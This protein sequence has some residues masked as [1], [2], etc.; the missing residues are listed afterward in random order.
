M[1]D[2]KPTEEQIKEFWEGCGFMW[3]KRGKYE[4]DGYIMFAP[5]KFQTYQTHIWLPL[6]DLNNLFKYAVPKTY[7]PCQIEL[8]KD[9]DT[10]RAR[11]SDYLSIEKGTVFSDKDPAIALFWAIWEVINV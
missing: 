8:L 6:V 3:Q 1:T 2:K 4:S 10:W 9:D 7:N 5:G 11:V